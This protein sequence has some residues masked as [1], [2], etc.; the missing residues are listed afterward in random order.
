MNP[1][2]GSRSSRESRRSQ[3]KVKSGDSPSPGHLVQNLAL[4]SSPH[5]NSPQQHSNFQS[6][7]L[8]SC[9]EG[10]KCQ[11]SMTMA[12]VIVFACLWSEVIVRG[13]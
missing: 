7:L 6:V 13:P 4:R 12:T 9:E 1:A 11:S 10:R 8:F 5:L 3:Q 2:P